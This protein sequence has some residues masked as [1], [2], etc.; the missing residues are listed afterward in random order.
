MME[1]VNVYDKENHGELAATLNA[2]FQNNENVE[3]TAAEL[4]IHRNTLNKRLKKIEELLGMHFSVTREK[5]ILYECLRI[6]ELF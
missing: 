6:L 3:K 2:Y 1:P 4:Y 5:T